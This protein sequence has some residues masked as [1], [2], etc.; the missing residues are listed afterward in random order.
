[1]HASLC[2]FGLPCHA[3]GSGYEYTVSKG[4]DC[5]HCALNHSG[6]TG[7]ED[8]ISLLTWT[9]YQKKKKKKKPPFVKQQHELEQALYYL[10]LP[11]GKWR[12]WGENDWPGKWEGLG[13][14]LSG[15]KNFMPTLRIG[16]PGCSALAPPYAGVGSWGWSLSGI[17]LAASPLPPQPQAYWLLGTHFP[18]PFS[19]PENHKFFSLGSL[20]TGPHQ[21]EQMY[22]PCGAL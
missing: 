2:Q 8:A 18:G 21:G 12:C 1:M 16:F 11:M 9:N 6:P 4:S 13:S 14:T 20:Q 3:V 15:S 5:G 10:P 22:F 19:V 7:S 17:P